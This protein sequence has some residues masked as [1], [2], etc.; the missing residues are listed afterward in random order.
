MIVSYSPYDDTGKA[1][2]FHHRESKLLM[3]MY[4][5]L[6]V[7]PLRRQNASCELTVREI[8]SRCLAFREFHNNPR[9]GHKNAKDATVLTILQ[10]KKINSSNKQNTTERDNTI[11]IIH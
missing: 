2:K 3:S 8:A 6:W 1:A 10:S 11:C 7:S 5:E 4:T 9:D